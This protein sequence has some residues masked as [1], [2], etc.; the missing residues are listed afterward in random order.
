MYFPVQGKEEAYAGFVGCAGDL[1]LDFSQGSSKND[2]K[3][4]SL[5]KACKSEVAARGETCGVI[6]QRIFSLRLLLQGE[7][8]GEKKNLSK[9]QL[10]PSIHI[11]VSEHRV[12]FG[13]Q[14]CKCVGRKELQLNVSFLSN[15][16]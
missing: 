14:T 6:C 15:T 9:R 3:L 7:S 10:F 13:A 11:L 16:K 12:W 5:P 2:I 8:K 4:H 1:A